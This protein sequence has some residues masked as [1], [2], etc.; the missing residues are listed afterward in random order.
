[1]VT[2]H[3][4]RTSRRA[5]PNAHILQLFDTPD[6]LANVVSAFLHEGWEAGEHL[7]VIAKPRHWKRVA[8]RLSRRGCSEAEAMEHGRLTVLDV[9]PVLAGILRGQ[10]V[11]PDQFH[12]S[13]GTLVARLARNSRPAA[14]RVYGEIVEVLAEEGNFEGA[15]QLETLWNE[16]RQQHDLVLLCGYSAAHFAGLGMAPAL[17]AIC[18]CHTRVQRN[19]SDLLGSWLLNDE[20]RA[21]AADAG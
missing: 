8:A 21:E 11:D 13:I 9:Q 15:R 18:D 12:S 16:L 4:R 1:M 14:L 7:L 19:A 10:V 17:R 5:T 6:S 2:E 3:P 20:L